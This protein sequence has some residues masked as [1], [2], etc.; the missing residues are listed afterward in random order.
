VAFGLTHR[1][2]GGTK[3]QYDASIAVVHPPGGLP[4]GQT[5]H[6]AGPTEDG[7]IV[8]AIWD[9]EDSWVRFRDDILMPGFEKLGDRGLPAP[10]EETTFEI[11]NA[12]QA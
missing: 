10:P 3:E 2:K 11:H 9:S 6:F 1:F 12:Q 7:W 4:E 5:H 8:V